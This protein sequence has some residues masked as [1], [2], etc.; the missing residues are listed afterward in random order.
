MKKLNLYYWIITGLFAAFMTSTAIPNVLLAPDSITFINGLLGYP[1]YFIVFIG[2]AKLLGVIG[3]LIPGFPRIKEWAYAGLAFDL[4]GATYS[5]IA[6]TGIQIEQLFMVLF[7]A[8]LAASYLLYHKRLK[9]T[10]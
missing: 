3:I 6:I 1:V 10:A 7:L 5:T 8:F 9:A 2:V 4:L